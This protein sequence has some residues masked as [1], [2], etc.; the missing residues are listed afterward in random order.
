MIN[1]FFSFVSNKPRN[2]G[3]YRGYAREEINE[4]LAHYESDFC[5]AAQYLDAEG[6]TRMAQVMYLLKNPAYE[7]IWWR[8][9][10][11]VHELA[12]V[13]GALDHYNISTILR[14]FSR[15]QENKMAGS[16]KLFVHLEPLI[17]KGINDYSAR[18]LS[19]VCYA[20][21][22]RNA[23]NPEIYKAIDKKL[24]QF[25][26][27]K[28]VLDYPTLANLNY[29]MMF[30]ENTNKKIWEH[31][32]DQTLEE[33]DILPITYYKPFKFSRFFL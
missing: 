24:M 21:S 7:N 30:R 19:H 17:I 6:I 23:G 5:D 10:N 15:A 31:I 13:D 9:E 2:F 8:I 25:A 22:V 11:R 29:Y 14:S 12:E 4:L 27:D 3:V 26:S 32:V 1:I 20:Y 16:N 33:D 28:E 18:D